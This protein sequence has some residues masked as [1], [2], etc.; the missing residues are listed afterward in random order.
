M[1]SLAYCLNDNKP[2]Q[3]LGR[4]GFVDQRFLLTFTPVLKNSLYALSNGFNGLCI[5]RVNPSKLI[6]SESAYV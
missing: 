5:A 3:V 4:V 2:R 6:R 1:L